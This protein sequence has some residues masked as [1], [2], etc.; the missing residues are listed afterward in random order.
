MIAVQKKSPTAFEGTVLQQLESRV[1]FLDTP[2]GDSVQRMERSGVSTSRR[3]D[4]EINAM[5]VLRRV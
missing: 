2:R 1:L 3:S 5:A 4:V